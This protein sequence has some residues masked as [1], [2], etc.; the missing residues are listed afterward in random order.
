MRSRSDD[1]RDRWEKIREKA[2][3]YISML[4][5]NIRYISSPTLQDPPLNA[6]VVSER[7][8]VG[9]A[10][11][12]EEDRSRELTYVEDVR[13]FS[14]SL[15]SYSK[16]L[17][18]GLREYLRS[19]GKGEIV[20]DRGLDLR[21]IKVNKKSIVEDLRRVKSAEEIRRIKKSIAIARSV[22]E[23]LVDLSSKTQSELALSVEINYEL[24]KEAHGLP[25]RTIV[26]SGKNSKYPHHSPTSR[27]LEGA[28]VCDFGAFYDGYCSDLTRTFFIGNEKER[29]KFEEIYDI[30]VKSQKS[31]INEIREGVR[32]GELDSA[33]RGII[34]M[35]GY[36]DRFLHS[37]G[38]GLGLEVHEDPA[39]TPKSD[40]R[41]NKNEV[42]T[43]EPGIYLS[44]FGIRIED[45][46]IV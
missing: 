25:F 39:I 26:A 16:S 33:A 20:S 24:M 42:I 17:K 40:E 5:G 31:A 43:I 27:K 10:S 18:S 9:F 14:A 21:P 38:H 13:A 6:V 8:V 2:D 4:S 44:E 11:I 7:E 22:G 19:L 46:F 34:E 29:E 36:G 15:P 3:V 1:I 32:C 23:K 45:D 35:E 12:M 28:V 30:V 41:L 37:T